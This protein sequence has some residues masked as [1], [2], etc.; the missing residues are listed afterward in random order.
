MKTLS[1]IVPAY[2]ERR[3]L[4]T[5]LSRVLAVVLPG[6]MAR[7][8]IIVDDCSTDGTRDFLRQIQADAAKFFADAGVPSEHL[9][10][11]SFR[12]LFHDEN[13][14]KGTALRTGFAAATGDIILI[15]DADLE[16]DPR[17]YGK[18]LRPILD[19]RADVVYGSRFAGETRRVMFFW[20]SMGNAFLTLLSNAFT[21]LNLTDMETCYKVFRADVIKGI[22]LKSE[23]FGIEPEMTAK[24]AKLRYRIYEV[25]IDYHGR[26]YAEGKKIG[27]KDGFEA[28]H[29]IVK[30]SLLDGDFLEHDIRDENLRKLKSLGRFNRH[31]YDVVRPSMGKRILELGAGAG[32]ITRHLL[33]HGSV[34]AS[35]PVPE[36]AKRLEREFEGAWGFEATTWDMVSS[37]S[38]ELLSAEFDTVVSIN[39]LEY[40]E[41]DGLVLRHS[42]DLLHASGGKLVVL[43]PA[44][45][46][47]YGDL[48]RSMGRR[49]RYEKADLQS[50]LEGAGFRVLQL[51]NF[52]FVGALGWL[53][54]SRILGRGQLPTLQIKAYDAV[55]PLVL[56]LESRVPLPYG[57][58]YV[59]VATPR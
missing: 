50:R 13:G 41:D 21:N 25:P 48:D 33:E 40:L 1:I 46:H 58:S 12:C 27:I 55:A 53:L 7:E 45:Q 20:H 4:V 30:Y 6:G 16:Y 34:T 22:R 18:L 57:L 8:I 10:G 43:V 23:R 5:L 44:H 47:L 51:E 59:A 17:D 37:P 31:I 52:N 14:G 54:N 15:Q 32:N 9:R 38:Q 28:L 29:A 42:R 2:N 49:R 26:T 24:I 36:L 35:D 19:G 39:T 11:A 56:N 3:T